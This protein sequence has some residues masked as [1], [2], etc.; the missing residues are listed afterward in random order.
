MLPA[1]NLYSVVYSCISLRV[2][3]VLYTPPPPSLFDIIQASYGYRAFCFAITSQLRILDFIHHTGKNLPFGVYKWRLILSDLWTNN[4]T[5]TIYVCLLLIG[6]RESAFQMV[7]LNILLNATFNH[8]FFICHRC[9]QHYSSQTKM[10]IDE[11]SISCPVIVTT[12]VRIP[13]PAP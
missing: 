1:Q 6:T 7:I 4:R 2:P 13:I 12:A 9:P 10:P 3:T 11:L 8:A 5:L